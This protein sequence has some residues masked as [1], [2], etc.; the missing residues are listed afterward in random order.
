MG[1]SAVPVSARGS[2]AWN[3]LEGGDGCLDRRR[4]MCPTLACVLKTFRENPLV[5][6]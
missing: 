2:S 4:S 6:R 1:A 3:H 5:P